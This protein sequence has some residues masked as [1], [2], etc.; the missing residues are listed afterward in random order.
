VSFS[1]TNT[2]DV[3]ASITAYSGTPQTTIV[4][5]SFAAPLVVEV[6]DRFG[7]PVPGETVTFTSPSNGA[8]ASIGAPAPTDST[9][10][11]SA[12]ATAGTTA[13]SYAVNAAVSGVVTQA[14]FDLTNTAGA[15]ASIAAISGTP[16]STTVGSAF[17]APL[18]VQVLDEYGNP[19]PGVVVSFSA[20]TGGTASAMLGAALVTDTNGETSVTATANTLSGIYFVTAGVSGFT[21]S[22]TLRN[23]AGV[24]ATISLVSGN[25]QETTVGTVFANP[26]VVQVLDAY[27]NPV[28]GVTVSFAPPASGATATLTAPAMTD[29]SGKTGV[30]ATAGTVTGDY[31]ITVST[32]AAAPVT[33]SLTNTAAAPAAITTVS[34]T[35]QTTTV[36]TAFQSP[37][38]VVVDDQFGNAVPGATVTFTPTG[39]GASATLTTAAVTD[40]NG[41]TSVTAQ[42]NTVA[43]T[44]TVSASV[45]GVPTPASFSLTNIA[46]TPASLAVVSG[47]PQNTVVL[48]SFALP[49]TVQ[50]LDPYGNP[51]SGVTPSFGAPGSG[52]SAMLGASLPTGTNGQTSVTAG[53]R[54]RW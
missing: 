49:L 29:T 23:K 12:N 17:S 51:V 37:L 16:Q 18:V 22:F 14:V 25:D 5:T 42:A 11:T 10:R 27:S 43:G 28:P 8:S 1:L 36:A 7:N 4:N 46:G 50:V 19:V 24:A 45:T 53:E 21:A 30:T 40:S 35:P 9:G 13:G 20:P 47:T 6:E 26:L 38:V 54:H 2:A 34:G 44:Y 52:A 48:T 41:E 39:S 32:G 3:P 33:F 31:S 15:P